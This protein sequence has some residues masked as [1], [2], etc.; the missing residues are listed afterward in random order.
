[1]DEIEKEIKIKKVKIE[2][3]EIEFKEENKYWTRNRLTK[4]D[5]KLIL[6]CEYNNNSELKIRDS[7]T[8][9]DYQ[10]SDTLNRSDK[11]KIKLGN[12]SLFGT[13]E[14]KNINRQELVLT[15]LSIYIDN[16]ES[17]KDPLS[18]FKKIDINK[19]KSKTVK[20][21]YKDDDYDKMLE[22]YTK[23][24]FKIYYNSLIDCLKYNNTTKNGAK[25]DA[26]ITY[27][28]IK[29]ELSQKLNISLPNS[30]IKNNLIEYDALILRD[31][32]ENVEHFYN[33]QDVLGIVEIKTSGYFFQNK[34]DM[35]SLKDDFERQKQ[36]EIPYIYI[37]LLESYNE[38]YANNSYEKTLKTFNKIDN[39]IPIIV[40]LTENTQKFTV[41]LDYDLEQIIKKIKE[42][43]K[44]VKE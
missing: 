26:M 43:E 42:M 6:F 21:L 16:K 7:L 39:C 34:D 11:I 44:R 2:D 38:K 23:G 3:F 10:T 1:M 36:D 37:A 9:T 28:V 13:G 5:W 29:K 25:F 40:S 27:E 4:K 18:L 30:F 41:P 35:D 22:I 17:T 19:C 12:K 32:I 14:I 33:Y 8:I 31:G 15:D 24:L 20:E